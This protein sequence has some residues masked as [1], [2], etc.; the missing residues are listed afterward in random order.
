VDVKVQNDPDRLFML[1]HEIISAQ[2]DWQANLAPRIV[3]GL[4]HPRFIVFAKARLPYCRRSYIGL[5]TYNARKYF[6]ND[7]DAFSIAFAALTTIDGQKFIEECK[8]S[9]KS[10]MVWT[11]NDPSHMME[12]VRWGVDAI[13]TDVTN[14]WLDLRSGLQRDYEKIVS[15]YGRIF[16]WTTLRYYTPMIYIAWRY[17]QNYLESVAGP[18]DEQVSVPVVEMRA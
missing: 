8:S 10:L 15:Q 13:I 18:F 9:G 17:S 6:W 2:P 14:T 5:S 1:M 4:W 11:V 16:L 7:C 3:L 12:A